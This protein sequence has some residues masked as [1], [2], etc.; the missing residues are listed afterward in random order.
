[1]KILRRSQCSVRFVM[2]AAT[3]SITSAMV[4]PIASTS[5]CYHGHAARLW[6]SC[7]VKLVLIR[8]QRMRPEAC[9]SADL[10]NMSKTRGCQAASRRTG[11]RSPSRR[12]LSILLVQ[13]SEADRHSLAGRSFELCFKRIPHTADVFTLQETSSV[14][15]S[16]LGAA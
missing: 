14:V 1:M 11:T 16:F 7:Q 10:A 15:A 5:I 8:S 4:T 13:V 3:L 9:A 12:R 6:H 2:P